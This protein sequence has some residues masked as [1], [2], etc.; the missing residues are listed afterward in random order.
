MSNKSIVQS[1]E[2]IRFPDFDSI[3]MQCKVLMSKQF[4]KY[5]NSWTTTSFDFGN[6]VF[7]TNRDFWYNRLKTEVKEFL[8]ADT[9]SSAKYELIDVINV[10]SMIYEQAKQVRD[11]YWRYS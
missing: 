2:E 3:V 1:T 11:P 6:C 9:A 8:K 5:K 7:D 10:S 4:P